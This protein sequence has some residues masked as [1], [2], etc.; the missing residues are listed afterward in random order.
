LLHAVA[1]LLIIVDALTA[2]GAVIVTDAVFEQVF[3]S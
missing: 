2:A 1:L 3:A